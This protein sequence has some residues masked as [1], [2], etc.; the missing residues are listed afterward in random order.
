[1]KIAQSEKNVIEHNVHQIQNTNLTL[2]MFMMKQQE[3]VKILL[4]IGDK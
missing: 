2:F 3:N 4:S 1:M